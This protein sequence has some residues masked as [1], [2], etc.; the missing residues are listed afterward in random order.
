MTAPLGRLEGV[1]VDGSAHVQARSL[2]PSD[3]STPDVSATPPTLPVDARLAADPRW[4]EVRRLANLLDSRFRIPGTKQTFGVDAVVGLLPGAGDLVGLV[5]AA[6]V[7]AQAVRL[8]VRGWTLG[9]MLANM[10]LDA[11]VGSIPLL[12]TV[13][14]VVYKANNRNVRLLEQHVHDPVGARAV[15]RRSLLRS[16][17]VVIGATLLVAV[18]LVMGIVWLLGQLV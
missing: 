3:D 16:L 12:G 13:F 1:R 7:V 17:V 15:A 5:A 11:T 6:Y 8:G 10:G 14:D 18:V 4:A 2:A 9:R